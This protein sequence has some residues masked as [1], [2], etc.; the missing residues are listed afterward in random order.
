MPSWS[1]HEKW[2]CKFDVPLNVA[3]T[4]N[5]EIDQT[6]CAVKICG[7]MKVIKKHDVCDPF[8]GNI[9]EVPLCLLAYYERFGEAG[10]RAV[11]LHHALDHLQM[12]IK[13]GNYTP[14]EAVLLIKKRLDN[15]IN[16]NIWRASE[17]LGRI[18]AFDLSGITDESIR[19]VIQ[20]SKECSSDVEAL[21]KLFPVVVRVI[22][23]LKIFLQENLD[24]IK[25]DLVKSSE[26]MSTY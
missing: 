2:A 23:D 7:K 5:R 21:E 15:F 4:V 22:N 11:L 9:K 6:G 10:I 8:P 13:R 3:K 20:F 14:E 16:A 19:D 18:S 12:L 24:E 25:E 17:Y 1:I 26:C